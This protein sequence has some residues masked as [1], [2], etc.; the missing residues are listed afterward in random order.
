M[1]MLHI[2]LL[3]ASERRYQGKISLGFLVRT[4]VFTA[5]SLGVL[6]MMRQVMSDV[7]TG[8]ELAAREAL[9]LTL[10]PEYERHLAF[11]KQLAK[12]RE[13][14][15]ELQGW[16][17]ARLNTG[18]LFYA[19]QHMVPPSIQLVRLT[20]ED[21]FE[22][23]ARRPGAGRDAPALA[24]TLR[25]RLAGRAHGEDAGAQVERLIGDLKNY[26]TTEDGPLLF[27]FVNLLS[28]QAP[29]RGAGAGSEAPEGRDFDI[30]ARGHTRP[31]P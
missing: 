29:A 26:R 30:E 19:L 11:E 12:A 7:L 18:A 31:I 28:I 23:P 5:A 25:M 9:W 13:Y 17:A 27:S 16:S 14:D 22:Q 3:Y 2:N 24:R 21:E 8:R 15:N 4:L 10:G 1:S 6:L 20:I